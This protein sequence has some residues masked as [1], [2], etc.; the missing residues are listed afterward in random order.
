MTVLLKTNLPDLLYQGKV[1]DTYEL[2]PSEL[3][4]VATDRASAFDVILPNGIPDKGRVLC[5]ISSFWFEKT[6]HLVPNHVVVVVNDISSLD[7]YRTGQF[8]E[9]LAGRSMVVRKAER[10][11]VECIARG[12]I[13]GSAWS[14][15][16]QSGT[17][18]GKPMP[19]GLKES[20]KLPEPI[21]TPSTKADEGHDETITVE[22]MADMVGTDLTKQV[23]EKTLE[24]YNFAETYAREK[25]I[26][27]ADTKMEFGM[28]D[29][30]LSL[31]D[32]LLTPDSSRFWDMEKYN[33]GGPQPSFDKQPLR[34]WL[35]DSGWDKEPP[36]PE[37]PPEV[38]EAMAQ[39]YRDAYRWL[40][41][42]E[43]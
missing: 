38:V 43:L 12:Y 26:I 9:Y 14:E 7:N 36:A 24:I 35:T 22:Q 3:L 25:G 17:V 41:G 31:I 33:P 32:E 42:M 27:I 19:T 16:Q 6:K 18:A 2:T 11:D 28:I 23:Q 39:R 20:D 8:P 40:T 5:Q 15:Y 29:G 37:L 30:K 34:D 13:S 1:R 4:L 10:I 21:F